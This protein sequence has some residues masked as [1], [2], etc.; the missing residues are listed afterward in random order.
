LGKVLLYKLLT[1][2]PGLKEGS[3]YVLVRGQKELSAEKRFEKD[4]LEDSLLFKGLLARCPEMR[5]KIKVSQK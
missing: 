2:C 4:I 1:S 5:S 3:L